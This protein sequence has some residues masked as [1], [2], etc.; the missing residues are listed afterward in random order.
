M[1]QPNSFFRLPDLL[2]LLLVSGAACWGFL[3][4]R[5]SEGTKA[6][7]YVSDRKFGWY[8]LAGEKRNLEVPTRIGPVRVEIGGGSARVT[9]SPCPNHICVKTGS[10]SH[11]HEEVVCVPA[12][13]LLVIEGEDG[14]GTKDGVDAITF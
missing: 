5:F 9:S 4:F 2:V 12:H 1:F 6:V 7:L 3:G 8:D 14:E 10:V 13:L 11:A